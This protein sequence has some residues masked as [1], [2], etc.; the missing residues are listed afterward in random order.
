MGVNPYLPKPVKI[1]RVKDETPDTKT[2]TISP[3][4]FGEFTPGQFA[5]VSVYG[6]GEAPFSICSPPSD[7]N[8]QFSIRRMGSVTTAIHEASPGDEIGVRGPYGRGWP[9]EEM[10]GRDILL[11]GGGIGFAPLRPLLLHLLKERS[12]Y[13]EIAVCYGARSPPLLMYRDEFEKWVENGANLYLTV[14]VGDG[15]WR[16]NVGVVTTI[17]DKPKLDRAGAIVCVCGPPV[18]IRFVLKKVVELGYSKDNVYA[19]LESKMRCGVGKCG[20]CHFGSKHV[21]IDGP[22]FRYGEMMEL[23]RGISPF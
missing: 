5:M 2:I 11:V 17:L 13:G 3:R 21:C 20:H 10:R 7:S 15:D 22:V 14:D 12:K 1:I 16:G 6:V 9:L 8:M 18:M 4:P 23:P 19:S